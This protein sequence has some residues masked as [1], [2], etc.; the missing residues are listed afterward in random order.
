MILI[1]QK[2]FAILLKIGILCGIIIII[3]F[4]KNEGKSNGTHNY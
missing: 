4:I 2:I 3:K 1:L